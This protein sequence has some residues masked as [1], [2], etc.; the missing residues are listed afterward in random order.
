MGSNSS[1]Y[2]QNGNPVLASFGG[3]NVQPYWLVVVELLF[4]Q[5]LQRLYSLIESSCKKEK[6]HIYIAVEISLMGPKDTG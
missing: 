3:F 5:L 6:K 4:L 2:Q 1:Y